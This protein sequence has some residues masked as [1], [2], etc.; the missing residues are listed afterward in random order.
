LR[1]GKKVML[2]EENSLL[3]IANL[4]G[5]ELFIFLNENLLTSYEAIIKVIP[6]EENEAEILLRPA[7]AFTVHTYDEHY[8]S[9]KALL[10]TD[11]PQKEGNE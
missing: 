2:D 9:L 1:N 8:K 10:N 5:V 3:Q 11:T 4:A 6:I 7:P